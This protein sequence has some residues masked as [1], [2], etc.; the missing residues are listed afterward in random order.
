MRAQAEEAEERLAEDRLRE[1]DGREH[2]QRRDDV[3]QDVARDDPQVVRAQGPRGFDEGEAEHLEGSSSDHAREGRRVDDAD[4]DHR[5]AP[6]GPE[7]PHDQDRQHEQR[8]GEDDVDEPH[9]DQVDDP[10]VEGRHE[11]DHEAGAEADADGDRA[12]VER[13]LGAV[14]DA[15]ERVAAE[16]VGAERVRPARR[17]QARPGRVVR[18]SR[19]HEMAEERRQ[20]DEADHDRARDPDRVAPAGGERE[21]AARQQ[22]PGC[23]SGAHETLILGSRTP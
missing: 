3:R 10:A 9:Q 18:I 6:R 4:R 17:L 20:D 21:P 12:D 23:S 19:P 16:V 1:V 22:A 8:E 15:R 5:V 14:D 13:H 7:Q 2:D 11:P